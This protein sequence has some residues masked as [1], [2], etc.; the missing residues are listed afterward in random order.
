MAEETIQFLHHVIKEN[1]PVT[2]LIDSNY[3]MLNQNLA[4]F[5]G[6][7]GVT[8]SHFRAVSL[9]PKRHRGGLLSQ[10]AFLSGHSDGSQ[11][12]PIKRAIWLKEKILGETPPPPP[13]NV[14]DL[15][16]ETPGFEELTLKQQLELHRDKPSCLNCHQKIDPYGVVFQN[17]DAVGRYQVKIEGKPVDAKSVLPDGTQVDGIHEMKQYILEKKQDKF[18]TAL[19]EHVFAWAMGRDVRFSDEREIAEIVGRVNKD[20]KT[21]RSVFRQIVQSKSFSMN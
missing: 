21:L 16:P 1:R 12:H 4:E 13:P 15:D 19:V 3:A 6:V 2:D 10:G 20:G 11:A 9:D 7:D 18:L 14:P 17:Y 8:G 5:Y